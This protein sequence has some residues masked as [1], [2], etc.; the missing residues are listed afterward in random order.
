MLYILIC[1]CSQRHRPKFTVWTQV[2]TP[3]TGRVCTCSAVSLLLMCYSLLHTVCWSYPQVMRAV[4]LWRCWLGDP[5]LLT[6]TRYVQLQAPASVLVCP[7]RQCSISMLCY[8]AQLA[9]CFGNV[10]YCS[11]CVLVLHFESS[12]SCFM[13]PFQFYCKIHSSTATYRNAVYG[14]LCLW[15]IY[16]KKVFQQFLGKLTQVFP[17]VIAK[18]LFSLYGHSLSYIISDCIHS[19]C[20]PFLCIG[21]NYSLVAVAL[22][23]YPFMSLHGFVMYFEE[24]SWQLLE[25]LAQLVE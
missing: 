3:S 16:I 4:H 11:S 23:N 8:S 13:W 18:E 6:T 10:H 19:E 22:C 7:H 9:L 15:F 24:G 2:S 5:L 1:P 25:C 12:T 17:I 20:L 14:F 21:L